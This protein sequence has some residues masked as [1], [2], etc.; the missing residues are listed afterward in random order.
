MSEH[1]VNYARRLAGKG[2][3][4]LARVILEVLDSAGDATP[5]SRQYLLDVL[6]YQGEA[7]VCLAAYRRGLEE[8]FTKL[9]LNQFYF[10]IVPKLDSA[11]GAEAAIAD[12]SAIVGQFPKASRYT[13]LSLST[14]LAKQQ[15]LEEAVSVNR[16]IFDPSGSNSSGTLMGP[17]FIVIGTVKGGTTSFYDYLA[18]HPRIRPALLKEVRFFNNPQSYRHGRSWYCS[19][20]PQ[21][22]DFLSGEAT[23]GYFSSAGCALRIKETVPESRL[24]LCLRD[25]A[26]RALSHYHMDLRE[27]R[28]TLGLGEFIAKCRR[29]VP[30]PANL[31][32]A[33][34]RI[35]Y[36]MSDSFYLHHLKT[37]LSCFDRAQLHVIFAEELASN[38]GKVLDAACD[39][40]GL[41]HFDPGKLVKRNVGEYETSDDEVTEL[42]EYL[43]PFNDGLE[44][45]L[46]CPVPWR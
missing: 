16:R 34:Y 2:R 8:G 19:H 38:P 40:L 6:A 37:W 14:L 17:S 25:P 11:D 26:R 41:E 10:N 39:F 45:V 44:A 30:S 22:P 4:D 13:A 46:G 32:E 36:A 3:L 15:R 24:I 7:G 12:L 28:I 18:S 21:N 23:P 27:G 5:E 29:E 31:P 1:V 35:P 20:F 42:H 9:A 33:I 43:Q